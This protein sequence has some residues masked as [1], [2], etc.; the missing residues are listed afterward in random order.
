MSEK[1]SVKLSTKSW[2]YKLIKFILGS[3]APTPYNMHNLCPYFW[4]L[5]FSLL[6]APIV[7]PIKGVAKLLFWFFDGFAALLEKS[8]LFPVAEN[9]QRNLTDFDVYQIWSWDQELSK[10]YKS[11][12]KKEGV[13]DN[14]EFA[15]IWW[16]NKYGETLLKPDRSGYSERFSK[17][18]AEMRE[19]DLA[20]REQ[21]DQE[22][23]EKY[24][25]EEAR[26]EKMEKFR[27]GMDSFFSKIGDQFRSWK[28]L[29]KWTKRIV[30]LIITTLGLVATFFIV[31]FIGRGILWLVL[32]WSWTIFFGV[33]ISLSAIGLLIGLMYVLK[34]LGQYIEAK[35]R[36]VWWINL[37]YYLVMVLFLPLKWIFYNFFWRTL[38]VGGWYLIK[39]GAIGLWDGILGFLGI[40]GEYFGAS[41]TDYCPGIDWDEDKK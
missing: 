22:K 15:K 21:K 32:N 14:S 26:Q 41:Y 9:W 2:H 30:G 23:S 7:A 6:A 29:I 12:H 10:I 18:L 16:E 1:A 35:G 27:V 24:L 39:R 4:L 38:C 34:L 28:N 3:A 25:K 5:V 19:K 36:K 37:L 40:F 33:I 17:W 13:P 31:N 20:L 11:V 8:L